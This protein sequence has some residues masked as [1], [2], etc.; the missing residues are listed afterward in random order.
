[1]KNVSDF[2]FYPGEDYCDT[3]LALMAMNVAEE[4]SLEVFHGMQR[5]IQYY[6]KRIELLESI[7]KNRNIQ[8]PGCEDSQLEN[9]LSAGNG[10]QRFCVANRSGEVAEM[11]RRDGG[12]TPCR[13]QTLTDLCTFSEIHLEYNKVMNQMSWIPTKQK[14]RIYSIRIDTAMG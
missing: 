10:R 2:P 6:L 5:E 12:K 13:W 9:P 11:V 1:M 4:E 3:E 8:I 7:L 14:S